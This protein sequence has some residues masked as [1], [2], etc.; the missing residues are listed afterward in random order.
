LI[1]L[2]L[3]IQSVLAEFQTL[4]GQGA[5]ILLPGVNQQYEQYQ[6]LQI[7]TIIVS[8]TGA[9]FLIVGAFKKEEGERKELGKATAAT[10]TDTVFSRRC[11]RVRPASGDLC[12]NCGKCSMPTPDYRKECMYCNITMSADSEFCGN[13]GRR[14]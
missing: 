10:G 7:V 1:F 13:C 12:P 8:M 14:L 9:G 3:Y 11:G 6:L 4:L 5:R 2:V